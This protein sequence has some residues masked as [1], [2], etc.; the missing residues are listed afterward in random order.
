MRISHE[1]VQLAFMREGGVDAVRDLYDRELVSAHSIKRALREM[2]AASHDS[3]AVLY[4]NDLD[5]LED[6]MR[7]VGILVER[8]RRPQ[9]GDV[10]RYRAQLVEGALVLR[11]PLDTIEV[12]KGGEVEAHFFNGSIKITEVT[13]G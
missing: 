4:A 5:E 10:R 11:L 12:E 2:R 7:E 8:N 13:R 1:K 6:W 3:P 9:A